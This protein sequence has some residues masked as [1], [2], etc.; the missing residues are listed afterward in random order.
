MYITCTYSVGVSFEL[1][2]GFHCVYRYD[3]TRVP[4][5]PAEQVIRDQYLTDHRVDT[6]ENIRSEDKSTSH[7]KPD[8]ACLSV[9]SEEDMMAIAASAEQLQSMVDKELVQSLSQQHFKKLEE[10]GKKVHFT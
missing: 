7:G 8:N 10:V 2:N 4:S 5:L 6:I 9:I 1:T 3:N